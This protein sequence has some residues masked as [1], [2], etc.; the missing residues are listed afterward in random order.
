[1]NYTYSE[2]FGGIGAWGKAMKIVTERHGDT[3]ELKRFWEIDKYASNA[4]S[5]IHE[6]SE[7]LNLWDITKEAPACPVDIFFYSPPC[8]TFSI[9]GKREGTTVDKGNLFYAAMQHLEKSRPKYAIMEN[10]KGLPSGDTKKDF[11]AMLW[12]L[13]SLG[14]YNYWKVLNTKDYG[15]PQNRE[16]VFIV[17]IRSDLYDQGKRFEF[18]KPFKLEKRLK[19]LLEEEVD[20]KYYLSE[21]LLR[22][23]LKTSSDE[24][25]GHLFNPTL[26]DGYAKTITT[27]EGCVV[28]GNFVIP[29]KLDKPSVEGKF[30]SM[31]EAGITDFDCEVASTVTAR[32]HKGVGGHKYNMVMQVGNISTSESFGG[33]PQTGRV[34]S[35]D[36]LSPTLST[37][38][39]GGQEPK[40]LIGASRGRDKNDPSDRSPGN[41]NLEQR[42]EI[43]KEG[44]SNTLTCVQKDNYV[45]KL[46]PNVLVPKRTEYGKNIRKAYEN[47]EIEES[48]HNMT[49]LE[50]KTDGICNTLS[51]VQKDNM[52]HTGISI[53]KLTPLE[54]F[55]LQGFSDEDYYKA[56]LAYDLKF[57][58][59]SI[60]DLEKHYEWVEHFKEKPMTDKSFRYL[61]D[62]IEAVNNSS[63]DSQM[64]KR[65]GN[66]IT[67]NVI[68][69]ILENLLYD[70]E[71]CGQQLSLF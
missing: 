57:K 55:R 41:D 44:I 66:S 35:A 26:G 67:V 69:E 37:M 63:S 46:E 22:S 17:S 23:F 21:K 39:G 5:A 9:A 53:R 4:F 70:R 34:Y 16:R 65:A 54:C 42:L 1:M 36:G 50:P 48:R 11:N 31:D 33:N 61:N 6:V 62:F 51:T 10:V 71:Q 20:Q 28:D 19:D 30:K 12:Y 13:E 25:N 52:I 68:V 14:Y 43:N 24:S 59:K 60:N 8:Q 64:Y 15:I 32:Y 38:Q 3:C 49:K 29:C 27:R 7:D 18:P 58:V 2:A 45:V 40:V 47:G 56:V